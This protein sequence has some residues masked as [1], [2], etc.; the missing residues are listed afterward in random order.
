MFVRVIL[1]ELSRSIGPQRRRL[2][3]EMEVS[4]EL[5]SK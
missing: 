4:F 3:A 1:P 5:R 2:D